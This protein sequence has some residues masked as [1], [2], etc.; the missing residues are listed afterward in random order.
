[1]G[2]TYRLVVDELP[3]PARQHNGNVA[4]VLRY[5]IPV[6]FYPAAASATNLTWSL[7]QRGGRV[8]VSAKNDGD[9]HVRLASLT[10]QAGNGQTITC[11]NGLTGYVLGHAKMAW[12]ALHSNKHFGSGAPV[13]ITAQSQSG[14]ITA[15]AIVEA[16]R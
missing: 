3:D 4:I 12:S 5:S 16:A 6:F 15:S 14:P 7:T 1:A 11:G 13:M 9:R 10:L 2:A 8:Y